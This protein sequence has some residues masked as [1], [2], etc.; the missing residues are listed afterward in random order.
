MD[1]EVGRAWGTSGEGSLK[2]KGNL[3]ALALGLRFAEGTEVQ[4]SAGL[5]GTSPEEGWA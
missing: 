4:A 5:G 3:V 1:Q 2:H